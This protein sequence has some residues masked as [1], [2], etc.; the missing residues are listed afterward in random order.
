MYRLP[1]LPALGRKPQWS[2][3]RS[4]GTVIT[5]FQSGHGFTTTGAD[6]SSNINDT[7]AGGFI[8]GTQCATVVSDGAGTTAQLKKTGL[9]NFDSSNAQYAVVFKIDDVT[10]VSGVSLSL[11][12]DSGFTNEYHIP[13]F[14]VSAGASGQWIV[15]TLSMSDAQLQGSPT[16]TGLTA[17]R[18][19]HKDDNTGNK[20]TIHYG[21]IFSMP[22]A[23][24][25]PGSPYPKGV[26]SISFDDSFANQILARQYLDSLGIRASMFTVKDYVG[27]SDRLT[28][29]QLKSMQDQSGFE[30]N[31]H[32]YTGADHATRFTNL[33]PQQLLWDLSSEKEW[34]VNNGFDGQGSAYPGGNCNQ[35]VIETVRKYYRYARGTQ[36]LTETYPAGDL[37]RIKAFSA[38]STYSGGTLP[39]TIYTAAT[40]KIDLAVANASWLN[41]V[42]HKIIPPIV[43]VTM[44][45]NIATIVFSSNH[46]FT[47]GVAITLAGFTPSGLNGN[48][49]IASLPNST[50]IT[51]NIGSNPGNSTVQGTALTAS[52]DCAYIDFTTIIDKLVSS[53]IAIKTMG[54]VID[55]QT[56]P[57]SASGVTYSATNPNG[58]SSTA[59]GPGSA[60]TVARSDHSHPAKYF[61]PTDHNLL[62]W[63]YDPI[64]SVNSTTITAGV[65]YLTK[66]AIPVAMTIT[67]VCLYVTGSGGTGLSNAYVALYDSTGTLISG[68]QSADVS[69]TFQSS[70]NKTI[71]LGAPKA[72]AA[73]YIW[74]AFWVG[75]GTTLPTIARA[76]GSNP[77]NF[78]LTNAAARFGSS[79]TAITTTPP[80]NLTA[81][82]TNNNSW[83]IGVS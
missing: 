34:L 39:N 77:I 56:V 33:T 64:A 15:I 18:L 38:L 71:P 69:T 54:E 49:T 22:N 48:F 19:F 3:D 20:V 50:T 82:T 47:N 4:V 32:A 5:E 10:H 74:V 70:S 29:A 9:A 7:T 55:G 78:G 16:R 2:F 24:T 36:N 41:L 44:A 58:D 72:V 37:F 80:S 13:F 1:L 31:A 76:S 83:W 61:Q 73:G 79:S 43:S 26:A 35:A 75:A 66:I 17:I 40:G 68:S 23:A 59:S 60:A 46:T 11:S 27:S 45:G 63:S 52:T 8:Y 21:G 14:N 6:A 25:Q 51:V 65:V 81:M 42:F 12:N 30:I 53:G 67:N 62:A 57:Q 28:L